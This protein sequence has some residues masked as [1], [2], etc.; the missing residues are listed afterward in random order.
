MRSLLPMFP[1]AGLVLAFL[2]ASLPAQAFEPCVSR[3]RTPAATG[4]AVSSDEV[5]DGLSAGDW[6]SIRAA[7]EAGRHAVHAVDGGGFQAWNPNQKWHTRFDGRGFTV[8]PDA[9]AWT[10]GLELQSYGFP[11]QEQMVSQQA[12]VRTG[13]GR[14]AYD[15]DDTLTEWY[16]N[17]RRGLENGYTVYKRPARGAGDGPLTFILAVRGGLTPEITNDGHGMRF[18]DKGGAALLTYTGLSVSDADGRVLESSFERIASGL[19][20]SIEERNARYPLTIDPIA[21]QAYLKASNTDAS[22]QFGNSVSVSGD[23]VVVGAELED[24]NATGVNG[25][26]DNSVHESGAVYV[27]VR[28]GT[29]WSQQAYLKASNTAGGDLFGN[30]VSLSGDTVIVGA[31]LEDSNATGV[32]GNQGDNSAEWS[33]AAYV[34]V[35]S[36]GIWSQ[37]AYLK[38]SNTGRHDGFG[39]SVSVSGDTVV[40]GAEGESSNATGVNGNQADQGDNSAP[41]SGAAYVF[42]RS[43]GIWSQEA[44]LK[45]SNTDQADWFGYSVS[46]SGDTVVV[47]ALFESSNATGVNGNQGNNSASFSGAAY[48]FVRSGGIWS[49]EAY[50]KASNTDASDRFGYSVSLSGDTVVVG[51]FQEA[52]SATGVNGNQADNSATQSGAAYVF[53]RSG[54]IWAQEAY[55]K[56]SNTDTGDGFGG[57]VSVSGDTVVVGALGECSNATGVNGNQADNSASA[58]GAAY[59]FVRNGTIWSQEAY[60]KASNTDGSDVFGQSVSLS[61]DTVVVGAPREDSNAKG[62]NGSQGD[63]LASMAG[64]AY[65]FATPILTASGEVLSVSSG[66]TIDYAI[67]FPAVDS[68]ASYQ[69]LLSV[70][71]TGPTTLHGLSIPLTRD[72]L[73]RA[74]LHGNTPVV[75]SGFQGTLDSLG[76]AAAHVVAPPFALPLKLAGRRTKLYLAVIN[77]NFDLSSKAVPLRF[78]L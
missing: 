69:I 53:V 48:V 1:L 35:R 30:S 39:R 27:F 68:G 11:G 42:V 74:S 15:W 50:L 2:P 13:G 55:L 16:V 8:T 76:D 4:R 51:A 70:H 57:S 23:T 21:Q 25:N 29:I 45:A 72:N 64:A 38:A 37:E 43:G 63:N 44:Y 67:D 58:A 20:L 36:G 17:D 52:S 73:F 65:V 5:P 60:L 19:R 33:G 34:F 56:A 62:V 18:L 75:T 3:D 40:V 47:G 22:D 9:G 12:R 31:R 46:V 28:S 26:Q 78:T 7:Y 24:S 14:V 32:N 66:G 10:W 6:S 61:G 41:S 77:S 59:V 49:H 71:G 54:T